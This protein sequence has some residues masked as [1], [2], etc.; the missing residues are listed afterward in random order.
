[1]LR[2]L[3][4]AVCLILLFVACGDDSTGPG[5]VTM[6][7]L[8]GT[9][10]LEV[11]EYSLATDTT[12]KADWVQTL[13]LT[14]I[15]EIEADGSFEGTVE[16]PSSTGYDYGHLTIDADSIY[17]NGEASPEWVRFVL[18]AHLILFWPEPE[19]VDFD[20]DGNPEDCFHRIEYSRVQ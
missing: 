2:N 8:A 13:G 18:A 3:G 4:S 7:D 12:Q 10:N 6:A 9:W 17:W 16:F 20:Q 5:Q 14:G 15:L 19:Y 1:M 11:Y